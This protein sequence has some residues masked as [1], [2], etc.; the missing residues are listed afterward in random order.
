MLP[1][2]SK[3]SYV[4][5]V[6]DLYES[7]GG[8]YGLDASGL[9][10]AGERY[11]SLNWDTI[12]R[13]PTPSPDRMERVEKAIYRPAA[14]AYDAGLGDVPLGK[15]GFSFVDQSADGLNF[16]RSYMMGSIAGKKE[17]GLMD[18]YERKAVDSYLGSLRT[19]KDFQEAYDVLNGE[20]GYEELSKRVKPYYEH[21]FRGQGEQ[22]GGATTKM[23]ESSIRDFDTSDPEAEYERIYSKREI[24]DPPSTPETEWNRIHGVT[25]PMPPA[26]PV[27]KQAEAAAPGAGAP[28]VRFRGNQ[29]ETF[30]SKLGVWV[31]DDAPPEA[32]HPEPSPRPRKGVR[33]KAKRITHGASSHQQSKIQ[34]GETH[35]EKKSR[36]LK[37]VRGKAKRITNYASTANQQNTSTDGQVEA[38]SSTATLEASQQT[39]NGAST[40]GQSG[41]TQPPGSAPVAGASS[42]SEP[43]AY[44]KAIKEENDRY[45]KETAGFDE[46][47]KSLLRADG[48]QTEALKGL[49][50][51]RAVA[52]RQ[53]GINRIQNAMD[54]MQGT[55]VFNTMYEAE[56]AGHSGITKSGFLTSGIHNA[57]SPVGEL[58][59]ERIGFLHSVAKELGLTAEESKELTNVSSDINTAY[60]NIAKQ[61]AEIKS[62]YGESMKLVNS[63]DG[64]A[65]MTNEEKIKHLGLSSRQVDQLYKNIPLTVQ[66]NMM[67]KLKSAW[68]SLT[69]GTNKNAYGSKYHNHKNAIFKKAAEER[70]QQ[71]GQAL[72]KMIAGR[73]QAGQWASEQI[74]DRLAA[75]KRG[76]AAAIYDAAHAYDGP[77]ANK[78]GALLRESPA[79]KTAAKKAAADTG[80][81]GIKWKSKAG[82]A[83][84]LLGLGAILGTMMGHHGEQSNAH[85]YNPNPQPQYAN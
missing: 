59:T 58:H 7:V 65:N 38:S 62:R 54:A 60:K 25:P 23:E 64:L 29:R 20:N 22:K 77:N 2:D 35:V 30:N 76:N 21:P 32:E 75:I 84:A 13:M 4:G 55:N 14:V 70:E 73:A 5:S 40:A 83:A 85:L 26:P 8:S 72:D 68:Y 34:T 12:S 41:A 6:S 18:M 24:P 66:E 48:D 27:S 37:G 52:V 57:V 45:T 74:A 33:G 49:E 79:A 69:E 31:V 28:Q 17:H 10:A 61:Q 78:Q 11:G 9:R 47:K 56:H 36:N 42:S 44:A 51:E 53:H 81:R 19:S 46:K 67:D 15:N 39:Q 16:A 50:R 1:R 3:E 63:K 82:A 43:S 80:G 71:I